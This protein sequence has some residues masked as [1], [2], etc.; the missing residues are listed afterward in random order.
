[1]IGDACEDVGE[2]RLRVDIVELCGLYQ[3][4]ADGSTLS[5]GVSTPDVAR[6]PAA[7]PLSTNCGH[8]CLMNK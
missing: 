7:Q 4:V 5:V 2:P 3:R 8:P 1:M 6:E